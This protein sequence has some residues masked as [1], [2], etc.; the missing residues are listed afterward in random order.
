MYVLACETRMRNLRK[1]GP[2]V[3]KLRRFG[4]KGIWG[5]KGVVWGRKVSPPP[6]HPVSTT[7]TPESPTTTNPTTLL[8]LTRNSFYS[9]WKAG[10]AS[11]L[12]YVSLSNSTTKS[13]DLIP[14]PSWEANT[15]PASTEE[16]SEDHITSVFRVRVDN[17]DRLWVMDTGLADILGS[18]KVYGKPALLIYDLNTDKL[19]RKYEFKATDLKEDSFFANVVSIWGM[20]GGF[21][22]FFLSIRF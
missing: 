18:P 11:S 2:G 20:F 15:L 3:W 14:Y 16:K 7:L 10:V 22:R 4:E 9:R 8:V 1:I 12:N 5:R 6:L 13:P 19:I 17:C 21:F